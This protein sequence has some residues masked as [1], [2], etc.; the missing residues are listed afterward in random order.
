MCRLRL[1][2]RG[3]SLG[4]VLVDFAESSVV[5]DACCPQAVVA[6]GVWD[7]SVGDFEQ[8][9]EDALEVVGCVA[10]VLGGVSGEG[11]VDGGLLGCGLHEH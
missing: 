8:V 11:W 6:V 9:V 3:R 10:D 2:G 4:G 7:V 1:G 5:E